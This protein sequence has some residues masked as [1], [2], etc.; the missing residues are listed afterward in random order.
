MTYHILIITSRYLVRYMK[1]TLKKPPENVS[2]RFVEYEKF[3]DLKAIYLE[4]ESWADGILTTGIVVQTVLERAID[5]P[6]KPIL[7]LDTDNESFYRIPLTLLIENRSLDPERI[8]FDVF[9][10]VEPRASVLSL[11]DNK[12]IMDTFP[13]FSHWLSVRHFH[14]SIVTYIYVHIYYITGFSK[15]CNQSFFTDLQSLRITTTSFLHFQKIHFHGWFL[16]IA[17]HHPGTPKAY[18]SVSVPMNPCLMAW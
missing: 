7:S 13:D 5:K 11:L 15:L 6:L 10:N 17:V 9:V 4:N 2:F 8:I 18:S 12:S 3:T 14:K 1:D 16:Y